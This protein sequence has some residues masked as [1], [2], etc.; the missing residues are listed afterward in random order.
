MQLIKINYKIKMGIEINTPT[1]FYPLEIVMTIVPAQVYRLKKE[2]WMS[3]TS[4]L[5]V[6]W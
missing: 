5:P 2:Y 4:G 3:N 1:N 6:V